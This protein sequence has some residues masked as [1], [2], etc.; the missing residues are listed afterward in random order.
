MNTMKTLLLGCLTVGLLSACSRDVERPGPDSQGDVVRIQLNAPEAIQLV[1]SVEGTNSARGGLTNVDWSAYDLRYQLA[2]Y[3]QDGSELL[4]APQAQVYDTYSPAT[5]EF[6]LTP[7]NTYKFVAWADFVVQGTTEDWHYNT[8]DLSQIS[9]KTDDDRDKTINDESRDAYFV[10]QNIDVTQTLNETLTLK[11]PFAKVRVVTTDWDETNKAIA[12]PDQFRLSYHDCTR[13]SGINAVTGEATG[14]ANADASTVYTAAIASDASGSKFYAEGYDANE[15]MRTL[16]V[17]YLMATSEQQSIHFNLELLA[18]GQTIIDRDFTTE[19]PIQRNYLTTL[20]GNILSIGGSVIIQIDEEFNGE[21]EVE[22]KDPQ[23]ILYTATQEL[24]YTG[25][26]GDRFWGPDCEFIDELCTYDAETGEGKWAY[27]G[28][29]MYITDAAFSGET[30]LQEISI[31]ASV[32]EVGR[33]LW[34]QTGGGGAFRDCAALE[35]VTFE[36]ENLTQINHNTFNGCSALSSIQLPESIQ[37]IGY[38]AF[39]RC[40]SLEEI[41]IP[42]AVTVIEKA[43]FSQCTGLKN[44]VIGNGVTEIG[45]NAFAECTALKT[46]VIGKGIQSIGAR[47]FNT[48]SSYSQMTLEKITVLFDDID[49]GTFPVLAMDSRG[50]FPKPGGWD[51]VTYKIYVPKGTLSAYQT[52]WSDY[53][54]LFVEMP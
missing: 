50:V 49:S 51:P 30:A 35:K 22:V 6:R 12:K 29:I 54:S 47:A 8:A 11:R 3:S 31:P 2:V 16:V 52:N 14:E 7:N 19:I 17:D 53:R 38:N 32:V 41:V 15:H 33:N 10:T 20:L 37:K 13:F 45:N 21:N 43:V 25:N 39:L 42:D 27:T 24:S 34:N 36:G 9:M 28:T 44:A 1:R 46:V 26:S 18:G 4:V 48:Q 5:F 23:Y 40:T